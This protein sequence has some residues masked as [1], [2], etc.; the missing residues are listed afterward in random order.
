[1]FGWNPFRKQSAP[2]SQPNLELEDVDAEEGDLLS[3]IVKVRDD[4]L[5]QDLRPLQRLIRDTT[6]LLPLNEPPI[7]TEKGTVLRYMTFE[8]DEVMCAFTDEARMRDF[9]RDLPGKTQVPVSYQTGKHLAEMAEYAD[10]RKIILNPNADILFALHPMMYRTVAHGVVMGHICDEKLPR[11]EIALGK[12]VAGMPGMDALNAFRTTL[13]EFGATEAWW[14]ALFLP[15]D[16]MRF[17]LGVAAPQRAFETLPDQ[18]VESWI[19]RWPLPTP[20]YVFPL[21]GTMPERD[22]AFRQT[23]RVL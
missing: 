22:A 15:P 19:G 21:D 11:E 13:G 16:E 10:L 2:T 1:M 6:F 17:C 23:D 5:G 8:D 14:A 3:E 7:Q 18:L 9:L 12:S 20:L 4:T